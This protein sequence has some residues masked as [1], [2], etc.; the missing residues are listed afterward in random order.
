MT[1][2]LIELSQ[3]FPC[4]LYLTSCFLFDCSFYYVLDE[5][6][7]LP[8]TRVADVNSL[9]KLGTAFHF[10]LFN[11]FWVLTQPFPPSILPSLVRI[12]LCPSQAM[13]QAASS[14]TTCARWRRRISKIGFTVLSLLLF[15]KNKRGELDSEIFTTST[16]LIERNPQETQMSRVVDQRREIMRL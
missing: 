15:S 7:V 10:V 1:C 16:L 2:Y 14:T 4:H 3:G 13:S 6:H 11:N 8:H 12:C 9:F 5:K